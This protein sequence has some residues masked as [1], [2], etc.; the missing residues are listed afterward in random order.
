MNVKL[1][2]VRYI[3]KIN[4]AFLISAMYFML[5]IVVK[6]CICFV[7]KYSDTHRTTI[8]LAVRL[9][10]LRQFYTR[11]KKIKR[12]KYVYVKSVFVLSN[13]YLAWPLLSTYSNP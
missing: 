12:L 10:K 2:N 13:T 1:W 6:V 4:T 5:D 8:T 9:A 7:S 3:L 11:D